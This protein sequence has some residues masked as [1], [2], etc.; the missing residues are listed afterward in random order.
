VTTDGPYGNLRGNGGMLST[1]HDLFRR[2]RALLGDEVLDAA[3]RAAMIAPHVSGGEEGGVESAYGYGWSVLT[4]E[5]VPLVT[6]DGGNGWSSGRLTRF[7]DDE[8]LVFWVTNQEARH[9]TWD[10]PGL[11]PD[12]TLGIAERLGAAAAGR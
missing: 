9:G 3:S 7:P 8:V 10:V 12:L 11:D 6:H 4:L 1:A 2:H 5:E